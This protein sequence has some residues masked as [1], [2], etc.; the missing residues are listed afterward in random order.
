MRCRGGR[1]RLISFTLV[2]LLVVIS[3]ISVLAALLLP[4]LDRA[5]ESA[6]AAE[7]QNNLRQFCVAAA[8][9]AIEQDGSYPIAYF[10]ETTPVFISFSWDFTTSKDWS[11]TPA[12]ESVEAGILWLGRVTA[13]GVHQCP[14]FEGSHNWL[15]D[16]HTGYNYNTSYI[17]HGSA[18]SIVAPATVTQPKKP[19][20]TALFGDGEYASGANKFMRAPY[21][22]PGDAGF[23]GR[24]AGT[25]G[26]RHLERTNVGWCDGHVS[27]WGERYTE[28][29]SF[30]QSNIADGTGFLSID[31]SL[32]DL[33]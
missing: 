17:G 23:S 13:Q 30:D 33:E 29:Y 21:A 5:V 20:E 27:A 10:Y 19:A 7:C 18:E 6:R 26:Y 31:N 22:N 2:E 15:A 32:Y 14:S 28:T 12:T 9:Y 24:S 1:T 25:Q 16:P 11:T 8:L 3:I 4:A